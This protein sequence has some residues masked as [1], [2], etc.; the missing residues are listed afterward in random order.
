MVLFWISTLPG[1]VPFGLGERQ[2]MVDPRDGK[3]G[4]GFQPNPA[5]SCFP[6]HGTPGL[7]A[8]VNC[9]LSLSKAALIY[10]LACPCQENQV[11]VEVE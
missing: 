10:S 1:R 4:M 8:S 7:S 6:A 3:H 9:N 2:I 11:S 5:L